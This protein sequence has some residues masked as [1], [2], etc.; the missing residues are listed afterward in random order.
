M[1]GFIERL[2]AFGLGVFGAQRSGRQHAEGAGEHGGDIG[3]DIAEQIVGDDHVIL[4]GPAHELH[5]AVVGQHMFKGH[6]GIAFG[7][8]AGDDFVPQHAGLH[9]V[10]LFGGGHAVLAGAGEFESHAGDA[11]DFIGVIDL[12]I[13]GAL[14]AIAEIGDGFGFAEINA[15]GQFAHDEDI[16]AVNKFA[17]EGRG[18]GKRRIADGGAQIGKEAQILAQAQEACFGAV[19]IGDLV[20]AGAAHGA[21]ENRIGSLR[22]FHIL[23]GNGFAMG[24][25]GAAADK[26]AVGLEFGDALPVHPGNDGFNLGHDF[27]ADTVTGEEEEIMGGH[28]ISVSR[29]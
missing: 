17:L 22:F 13:D 7:L 23:F 9:H 12:R 3:E 14:L 26:A 29:D 1:D 8:N 4:L 27:R 15:A 11:L 2:A 20:P 18:F 28:G 6:I 19:D 25:I 24:I 10:A 21:K 16:E 5:G